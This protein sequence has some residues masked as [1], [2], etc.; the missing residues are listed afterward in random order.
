MN[1]YATTYTSTDTNAENVTGASILRALA[2]LREELIPVVWYASSEYT[3]RGK[4][5]AMPKTDWNPEFWLVNDNDV[6]EFVVQVVKDGGL[7]KELREWH[8]AKRLPKLGMIS[9]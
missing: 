4:A 2:E 1:R 8:G 9:A 3:E 6:G 7:P 5:F